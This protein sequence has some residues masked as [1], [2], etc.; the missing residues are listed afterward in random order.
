MTWY[1][2]VICIYNIYI[3]IYFF[4]FIYLSILW[5]S[6]HRIPV[7]RENLGWDPEPK[8]VIILGGDWHPGRITRGSIPIYTLYAKISK[9][10]TT[11]VLITIITAIGVLL[12][13]QNPTTQ[14]TTEEL[15]ETLAKWGVP[16]SAIVFPC[17]FFVSWW[18]IRCNSCFLRLEPRKAHMIGAAICIYT[19]IH[20]CIFIYIVVIVVYIYIYIH[21]K[22]LFFYFVQNTRLWLWN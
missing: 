5:D 22:L 8:N 10:K 7:A 13:S 1:D 17:Y 12:S 18:N 16:W 4:L 9:T 3:Y 6:P 20:V 2:K 15:E 19:V 14:V 21:F 11:G